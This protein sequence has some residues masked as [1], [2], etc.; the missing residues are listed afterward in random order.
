MAKRKSA[1]ANVF[2]WDS[3][4]LALRLALGLIFI[5]HGGQ[6]IFGW[7]GGAGWSGTI[8]RMGHIPA[9]LVMA[10]MLTEFVGGT[11]IIIGLL[12]RFWS[13]GLVIAMAVAIGMVHFPRGWADDGTFS[14][15]RMVSENEYQLSLLTMA[16]ALF[17]AGPG[18]WALADVEGWVLGLRKDMRAD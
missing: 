12:T 13:A 3:A 15:A 16:L 4:A 5:W 18:R 9:P 10:L 11:C 7:E 17:L 1:P 2:S 6:K 8:T 14:F